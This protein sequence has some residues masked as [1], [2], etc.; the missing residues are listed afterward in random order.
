M[1]LTNTKDRIRMTS[2]MLPCAAAVCYFDNS[3]CCRAAEA[4]A[5]SGVASVMQPLTPLVRT[6]FSQSSVSKCL[7]KPL[8]M[9]RLIVLRKKLKIK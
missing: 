8:G 9:H 3:E 4:M 6:E 2:K 5:A 1:T 7:H